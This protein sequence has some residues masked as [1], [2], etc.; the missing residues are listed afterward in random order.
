MRGMGTV[1]PPTHGTADS[2]AP[3]ELVARERELGEISDLLAAEE[4]RA[5]VLEG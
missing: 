1:T 3:P 5:L 2:H 4:I